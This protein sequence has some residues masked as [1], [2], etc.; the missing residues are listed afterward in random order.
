MF[1]QKKLKAQMVL[2]GMTVSE[3]SKALDIDQST[4]HRKMRNDGSFTREEINTIIQVLEIENP[5]D[6][7]FAKE[8]A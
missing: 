1:N 8:L 6:I 3:L 4:F 5:A 7:F 2:K